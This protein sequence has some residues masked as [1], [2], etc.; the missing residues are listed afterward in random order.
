M[1]GCL[2]YF[3]VPEVRPGI[4][5]KYIE[6]H[7]RLSCCIQ[8]GPQQIS[9]VFQTF[10]SFTR[11]HSLRAGTLTCRSFVQMYFAIQ[12]QYLLLTHPSIMK[13]AALLTLLAGAV[14]TIAATAGEWAQCGGTG[15]TGPTTCSSGFTCYCQ[16]QCKCSISICSPYVSNDRRAI[17]KFETQIILNASKATLAGLDAVA[18]PA[19]SLLLLPRH[20]YLHLPRRPNVVPH[21]PSPSPKLPSPPLPP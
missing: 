2:L 13:S 14:G 6:D 1:S 7:S 18:A 8:V 9:T 3:V 5:N 11:F 4:S 17:L 15:F 20:R 16:S 10:H 21:P 12:R 19:P